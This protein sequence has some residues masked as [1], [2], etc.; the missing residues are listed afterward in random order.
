MAQEVL[1]IDNPLQ[2]MAKGNGNGN[3]DASFGDVQTMSI[4]DSMIE[5]FTD[6]RDGINRMADNVGALVT[7]L[8]PSGRDLGIAGADVGPKK[9]MI[10]MVVSKECLLL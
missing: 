3:G 2:T 10:K 8:T 4:M 6:M 9:I 5:I 7:A 1:V